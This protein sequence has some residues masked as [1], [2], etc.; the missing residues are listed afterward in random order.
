MWSNYEESIWFS[1]VRGDFR[2]E[3]IVGDSCGGR[4]ASGFDLDSAFDFPRDPHRIGDAVEVLGHV[5]VGFVKR[6]RFDLV[7]VVMED[8]M[9]NP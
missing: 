1:H 6:Q 7:G 8:F 9:D 2:Q 4:Q 3:H 5:K